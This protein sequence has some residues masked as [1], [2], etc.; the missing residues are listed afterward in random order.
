MNWLGYTVAQNQPSPKTFFSPVT[1]KNWTARFA[2]GLSVS[3]LPQEIVEEEINTSPM[4]TGGAKLWLPGNVL[5]SCELKMNYIANLSTLSLQWVPVHNKFQLGMGIY[6]SVWFG[7]LQMRAIRLKSFGVITG[8]YILAGYDFKKVL[9]SARIESQISYYKTSC[10]DVL[11]HEVIQPK[12]G[13]SARF[14]IEQPLWRNH[15]TALG[16]TLNYAKFYYQS[17]LSYSTLNEYL[18]FPE[19]TFSFIL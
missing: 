12:S 11:L 15:W 17:W 13:I 14:T 5:A 18:I 19:I 6:G 1:N 10:E 4:L 16:F 8:P 7:H 2:L 9:L 3:K